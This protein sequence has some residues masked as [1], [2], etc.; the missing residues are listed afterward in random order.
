MR[1]CEKR[2]KSRDSAE[3]SAFATASSAVF[4]AAITCLRWGRNFP[5]DLWI[6]AKRVTILARDLGTLLTC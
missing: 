1:L 3:V 5:P 2:L 6:F 4:T